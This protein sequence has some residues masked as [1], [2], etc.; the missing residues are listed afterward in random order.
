MDHVTQ[1]NAAMVEQSTAANHSLSTEINQLFGLIGQFQVGQ[2]GGDGGLRDQLQKAAPH[3]F[4]EPAKPAVGS[5][6][7]LRVAASN[8]RKAAP[9]P[10][11]SASKAVA[12]GPPASD[13]SHDWKEF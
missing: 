6:T 7:E 5:K 9:R 8:A 2:A 4:R 1:Q 3:A 12:N 10:V 11:R 13:D